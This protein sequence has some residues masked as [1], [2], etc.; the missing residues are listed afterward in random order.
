VYHLIKG[1]FQRRLE[2]LLPPEIPVQIVAS[3][4]EPPSSERIGERSPVR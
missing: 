4:P 3:A 2:S 1:S